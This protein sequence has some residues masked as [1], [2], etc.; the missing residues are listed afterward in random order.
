M[1]LIE[2]VLE[3]LNEECAEVIQAACKVNRFAV[4]GA[5]P[6]GRGNVEVLSIELDD[7]LGV[8][9]LLQELGLPITIGDRDRIEAKKRK[10][11][12][13]MEVA[14]ERGSLRAGK[15]GE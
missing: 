8:V 2:H 11:R 3:C 7:V 4:K 14:T 1:N 12:Q 9:E 13:M 6:D 5:Y 15:E 10:L